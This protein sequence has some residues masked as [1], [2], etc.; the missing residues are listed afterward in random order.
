MSN[1]ELIVFNAFKEFHK[2]VNNK[3][4]NIII[5]YNTASKCLGDL[6]GEYFEKEQLLDY[7]LMIDK[8]HLLL[9]YISFLISATVDDVRD[10]AFFKK[11]I[12]INPYINER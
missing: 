6:I 5:T 8:A 9:Q 3:A 1:K 2:E 4:N 10:F 12:I 11:Y 7:F